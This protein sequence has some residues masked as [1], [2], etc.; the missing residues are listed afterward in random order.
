MA[1]K[2]VNSPSDYKK[3]VPSKELQES[4]R[5]KDITNITREY[6]ENQE[7]L[8]KL[9][10]SLATQMTPS[11]RAALLASGQDTSG[12]DPE[13]VNNLKLLQAKLDEKVKEV[14][15]LHKKNLEQIEK[16]KK[17]IKE[18]QEIQKKKQ[19]E[20]IDKDKLNEADKYR[21]MKN[22]ADEQSAAMYGK[23]NQIID[24]V[25]NRTENKFAGKKYT[26]KDLSE[27]DKNKK[28]ENGFSYND[29]KQAQ[30]A[31]QA[32]S[33]ALENAEKDSTEKA[34]EKL[35]NDKEYQD[36]VKKE[37]KLTKENEKRIERYEQ[38]MYKATDG[39]NKEIEEQERMMKEKLKRENYTRA[40]SERFFFGLTDPVQPINLIQRMFD[41]DWN[42]QPV[43]KEEFTKV[44]DEQW[45]S[46]RFMLGFKDIP[47][48]L[49][50]YL[51]KSSSH[52]KFMGTGLGEH[53]SCN[54]PFQ[55]CRYT[56][57]RGLEC[58][59]P[60]T[61]D[62]KGLKNNVEKHES[63]KQFG[64]SKLKQINDGSVRA[65]SAVTYEPLWST[66]LGSFYAEAIDDNKQLLFLQFGVPK[67]NGL[68]DVLRGSV[69]YVDACI[70]NEGRIPTAYI[71]ADKWMF[72]LTFIAAPYISTLAL[73][74]KFLIGDVL[75]GNKPY[76]YYYLDPAMHVYWATVNTIANHFATDLGLLTP[77][78]VEKTR[79]QASHANNK[80]IR[81]GSVINFDLNQIKRFNSI[82]PGGLPLI[83]EDTGYIDV[84][85][86]VSRYQ[87]M[88]DNIMYTTVRT[89]GSKTKKK[90]NPNTD[91]PEK[92][93]VEAKG[94]GVPESGGPENK[95]EAGVNKWE[96]YNKAV[97]EQFF[98]LDNESLQSI[99]GG[100][101]R[102]K[103][104]I[105][106]SFTD[107]KLF[108]SDI[109][110]L[111]VT[112][113]NN[114]KFSNPLSDKIGEK[115][116]PIEPTVQEDDQQTLSEMFDDQYQKMLDKS[117]KWVTT[118]ANGVSQLWNTFKTY[119]Y[120]NKALSYN[121]WR[122]LTDS[123]TKYS[124]HALQYAVFSVQYTGQAS[125]SFS[126]S[127]GEMETGGLI[128]SIGRGVRHAKFNFQA[129]KT[130]IG[131]LD[132]TINVVK[133]LSMSVVDNVSLGLSNVIRGVLA[134]AYTDIPKIWE[135]SSCNFQT[136]TYNIDLVAPYGNL[137]SRFQ[138]IY[139]PLSMLLAGTL[140]LRVGKASYTS[141]FLCSAYCRGIQNIKLGMITDLSITRAITNIG[142][143]QDK[144]VNGM[145]VSFTITDF[146]HQVAAPI[147]NT[148]YSTT[149]GPIVDQT[150]SF[151]TY[152]SVI[153]AKTL[154]DTTWLSSRLK[155][156]L[157]AVV[158]TY[159][160]VLNP[161]NI[162]SYI[163]DTNI[164]KLIGDVFFHNYIPEV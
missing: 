47:K 155:Y 145:S 15:E 35:N 5:P 38:D 69:S 125:E 115:D 3:T 20:L 21:Q 2:K 55:F 67:F 8:I 147:N 58:F 159:I 110:T 64:K 88:L 128:K 131:M 10:K 6:F 7:E 157:S 30:E 126:N 71:K 33:R 14:N 28:D 105:F 95:I 142:F 90:F 102:E 31:Y 156:R 80:I 164:S 84:R 160:G 68:L 63:G 136:V 59:Y 34:Y 152:S 52:F 49:R 140:P 153:T 89:I 108:R 9:Q 111:E 1:G 104:S 150:S 158:K 75:L 29:Y 119:A 17:R 138:N 132:D 76:N 129:G 113:D 18:S 24:D 107:R 143:T 117:P 118:I 45:V 149:F 93:D 109:G 46:S 77:L 82:F 98:E 54:P 146:E 70:A 73:L 103:Q 120:S 137:Y 124:R 135:D 92:R 148:I 162:A 151:A 40:L 4:L 37:E 100:I 22:S 141:P 101:I 79:P 154:E 13:D 12:L 106:N 122:R 94:E 41:E 74:A 161:D 96:R 133:D 130:G 57:P 11:A 66:G 139:L 81:T 56:D 53:I 134:G 26:A 91:T 78:T 85:Y 51:F 163:A 60:F 127:V 23:Q 99:V 61:I 48:E 72:A 62:N 32:S 39:I 25:N 123:Y 36:E 112:E 19:D 42:L 86:I 16:N 87:A 114:G 50:G 44:L 27:E 83:D 97:E 43:Y 65:S 121:Y 144:Q 116:P